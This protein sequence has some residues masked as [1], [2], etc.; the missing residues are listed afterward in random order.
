[1][2]AWTIRDAADL[3][4]VA[5]WGNGYFDITEE[6][7]VVLAKSVTGGAP[8]D[9]KKVVDDL[10]RRGLSLPL[11]LRF[12]DVLRCRIEA[13]HNAFTQKIKEYEY[14]GGYQLVMPIKVNQQRHVVEEV[15]GY[16]QPYGLGLEAGSKPELLVAIALVSQQE[17]GLIVCNGYKDRAYIETALLAQRLGVKP[18]IIVDRF[19][20]LDMIIDAAHRLGL[21]PNIG[22]RAKLSSKGS[23]RWAESGGD[24]SKFGLNATELVRVVERLREVGMLDRLVC[25]HFHIG[26]QITAIRAIKDA[27]NE[28]I[29]IFINLYKMG[30]PLT[31]VDVGGGLAVDYD[32]SRTN[33]HASKNYSMQE[34]AADIVYAIG[35]ALTEQKIPHPTILSESGRALVAHHAVLVFNVLGCNA[36]FQREIP[37]PP[38]KPD[39]KTHP[40]IE[41]LAEVAETV[42]RKNYQE[43][44]ND[45]IQLKEDALSLFRHGILDLQDRARMEQLFWKAASRILKVVRELDYIPEDLSTLERQLCDTYFCNFSVFQ[46]VP[47]AWAVKHLFPIMPL[48]RLREQPTRRGV[49][50]DLT[51]DSDGK[52]NQFI[53]LHDVKTTLELHPL[54]EDEPYILG[55]F[56]VGAYQE[57][58]GDLHNLFGDVNA[59]HITSQGQEYRVEHVVEGDTVREVLSYVEYDQRV[60]VERVRRSIEKAISRGRMTFEESASLVRHFEAGM[61]GYTYL[62]DQGPDALFSSLLPSNLPA[63]SS[64]S[65]ETLPVPEISE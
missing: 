26:S 11:L 48:H 8:L 12:S 51:C 54:K 46:S 4:N 17:D 27:L 55:V 18:I 49:L 52:I 32:G 10:V 24:K 16:G 47:D 57:T 15:L 40:L 30:A 23:G 7:H 53:D 3:Y 45:A 19:A 50:A 22:V 63:P 14:Q 33:F 35:A 2:E 42:T 37:P 25:L 21:S 41:D 36:G 44:Y 58:L 9:I 20:E 64:S 59:V 65:E 31:H 61:S 34:Y 1:M 60:L 5:G 39:Q 43:A 6:G 56:L 62:D 38:S 13:L 28:A 29:H